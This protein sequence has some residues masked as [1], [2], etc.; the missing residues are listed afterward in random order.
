MGRQTATLARAMAR[1]VDSAVMDRI[2]APVMRRIKGRLVR[3]CCQAREQPV[4][5]LARSPSMAWNQ[6]PRSSVGHPPGGCQLPDQTFLLLEEV[7]G[8]PP[9]HPVVSRLSDFEYQWSRTP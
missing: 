4:T 7:R 9:S 2:L 3:G 1:K 5:V 8:K 6:A